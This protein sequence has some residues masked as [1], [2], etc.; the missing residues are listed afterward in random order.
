MKVTAWFEHI[1][2]RAQEREKRPAPSLSPRKAPT[3]QQSSEAER[4]WI[5]GRA[6]D[7]GRSWDG[8]G[9]RAAADPAPARTNSPLA[10]SPARLRSLFATLATGLGAPVDAGICPR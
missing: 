10:A 4:A 5:R 8:E 3:R 1:E 7:P 6:G 9:R 2:D